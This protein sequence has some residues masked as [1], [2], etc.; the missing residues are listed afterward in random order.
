MGFRPSAQ[1]LDHL[2]GAV[3][4][5]KPTAPE[6]RWTPVER[7]HVTC[8][9]LGEVDS[10]RLPQVTAALDDVARDRVPLE[11]LRLI[12]SGTFSGALWVGLDPAE[13][14][15]PADKLARS[16]QRALR[17]EGLRIERRPWRGHLTIA[18]WKPSGGGRRRAREIVEG[19]ADY[20]GPAFDVDHISLVHSVTGP[21]P[22]Y[23]DLHTSRLG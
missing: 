7:W 14:G 11:S 23:N 12:G 18:R 9:F 22:T 5:I 6:L 4:R 1:A 13:R 17:Q 16:I 10:A 8:A 20:A 15:S 19:L 3:A 21:Q 2:S